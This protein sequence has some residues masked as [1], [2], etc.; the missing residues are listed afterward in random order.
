[1]SD[2]PEE[3]EG[4]FAELEAGAVRADLSW[5]DNPEVFYDESAPPIYKFR[6]VN[7]LLPEHPTVIRVEIDGR[8]LDA[9]LIEGMFASMKQDPESAWQ[10]AGQ[11]RRDYVFAEYRDAFEDS[12]VFDNVTYLMWLFFVRHFPKLLSNL[13]GIAAVSAYT[14]AA[15]S[16][17]RKSPTEELNEMEV[18]AR[19]NIEKLLDD[20]KRELKR[21]VDIRSTGRPLGSVKPAE[22]R[23]QEA[24]DFE[25]EIEGTIRRLLS[26]R[27]QM[28]SKTAVAKALG[29]GGLNP[30]T[31][32]DSSL[33]AFRNKLD[34]LN[35]DYSA[36]VERMRLNK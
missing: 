5:Y 23:A 34:R 27:G 6:I 33:A 10:E 28:P 7:F 2:E 13:Y 4:Q 9:A 1:M 14:A 30:A 35:V 12:A 20:Q 26:E 22:K 15:L 19:S 29:I 18:L 16:T 24:A 8:E 25:I 17:M 31:G 32:V 3:G 36:I 21:L 11:G